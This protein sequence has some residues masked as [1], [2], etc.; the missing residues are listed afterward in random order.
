LTVSP[1]W[2]YN[3]RVAKRHQICRLPQ[4][5]LRIPRCIP[6]IVVAGVE[7]EELAVALAVA[8]AAAEPEVAAVRTS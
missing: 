8:V 5:F 2:F 4:L 6:A 3:K 7:V 1:F